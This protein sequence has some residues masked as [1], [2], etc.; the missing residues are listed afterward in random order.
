MGG[1]CRPSAVGP[2]RKGGVMRGRR[3]FESDASIRFLYQPHP[4][5]GSAVDVEALSCPP[6]PPISEEMFRQDPLIPYPD[7]NWTNDGKTTVESIF[8]F[9]NNHDDNQEGD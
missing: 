3:E 4:Y 1:K 9:Q 7:K 6:A 5:F 8:P 2:S